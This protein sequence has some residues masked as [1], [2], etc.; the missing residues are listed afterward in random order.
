MVLLVFTLVLVALSIPA[1]LYAEFSGRLSSHFS[2]VYPALTFLWIGPLPTVLPFGVPLGGVFAVI[3]AVYVIM[4]VFAATQRTR[5]LDAIRNSFRTGVGSLLES[6]LLLTLISI[7]FLVFTTSWVTIATEAAGAP[8][9][10][11]FSNVDPLFELTSVVISPL[12]EEVGFRVLLV[13]VVAL[14]LSIGRPRKRALKA[15]W[16]PSAAYE[17]L[18]V[19]GAISIIVWAAMILSSITFG[20]CHVS[21]VGGGGGWDWGKLPEAIYGGVVLGYLYVR[22]G[23]HVAVLAHWGIDYFVSAFAFFGQAAYGIAWDSATAEFFGQYV[24]DFDLLY[25]FGLVSFLLV[26]YVGL[27]KWATKRQKGRESDLVL[28]GPAGGGTVEA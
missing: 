1:G 3:S 16:R 26:I 20:V 17:G 21:C 23:L 2:Y 24:I 18:A 7:G 13:G 19:G 22:F 9:G 8:I 14:I 11:P 25:L 6:P 10:N 4:F 15:L 5:P 12:R 27:T 28:K